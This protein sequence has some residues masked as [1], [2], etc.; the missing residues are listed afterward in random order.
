MQ[1]LQRHTSVLK[2]VRAKVIQFL[3]IF[4]FLC[5]EV[6]FLLV[7]AN[8]NIRGLNIFQDTYLYTAYADD[9]TFV[10]KNKNSIR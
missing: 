2:K 8:H 3:R 10:L 5:L 9:T 7:K 1:E 6:L 4:L